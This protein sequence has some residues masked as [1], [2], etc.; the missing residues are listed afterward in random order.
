MVTFNCSLFKNAFIKFYK[1]IFNVLGLLPKKDIIIFESYL[2]KQ[3]SCNPRSIYEYVKEMHPEYKLYWSVDKRYK[4]KFKQNGIPY[5]ERLSIKW[6]FLVPR[7]KFWISNSRMPN[8]I[9]KPRNTLYLQTWHGTP[10]KKLAL[11]I[12]EIRMPGTT[13]EAYKENFIKE[14][15]KWDYLISPNSYSTRIFKKAFN[16]NGQILETGYPRN[17]LLINQNNDETINSIKMK[18]GIPL[19]SKII[20]YAPTWRDDL[21]FSKGRY[22]FDLKMDIDEIRKKLGE[23]YI[24]LFRMHYLVADTLNLTD[25]KG[26]AINVSQHDDIR[27]LYLISD[28]LITDYSSV[29]FDYLCLKRPIIFF[30]YDIKQY[31]DKLRGFYFDFEENAPGNLVVNTKELID[32]II[33]IQKSNFEVQNNLLEFHKRF[34]RL[35]DGNA[36]TRVVTG[37]LR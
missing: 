33:R 15:R 25:Y 19:D 10:L 21:Y 4:E 13:T 9:T 29:F 32:E 23:E 17:D 36:T 26:F 24:I 28:I 3:Y 2:G 20:M 11:D 31:R 22:K 8:W 37:L 12:E 34:C 6:L 16:Y 14:T 5:L 27:E 30:T 18:M 35:E 1:G 7:A